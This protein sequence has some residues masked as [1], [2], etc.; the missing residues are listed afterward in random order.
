MQSVYSFNVYD[1]TSNI[2]DD[3]DETSI[4]KMK[5]QYGSFDEEDEP[6][7]TPS[8][9]RVDK[10]KEKEADSTE[11]QERPKSAL[12]MPTDCLVLSHGGLYM[13]EE[14]AYEERSGVSLYDIQQDDAEAE[15][16]DS[17]GT[18]AD[19]GAMLEDKKPETESGYL[20]VAEYGGLVEDSARKES[21][22]ISLPQPGGEMQGRR[23]NEEFQA[24]LEPLSHESRNWKR[25]LLQLFKVQELCLDFAATAK[26]IGTQ[27]IKEIHVPLEAKKYR[28]IDIG[29]LAGGEKYS[30]FSYCQ[31]LIHSSLGLSMRISSSSFALMCETF[32]AAMVQT[33]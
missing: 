27:I 20:T 22:E 10:E 28:P 2:V 30:P 1:T 11:K 9:I 18:P 32:M 19:Y 8:A 13:A 15:M 33:A 21:G 14:E 6:V 25:D 4:E 26:R 23:W 17:N 3:T 16:G 12:T 24:L 29:G 31:L 7:A 5:A